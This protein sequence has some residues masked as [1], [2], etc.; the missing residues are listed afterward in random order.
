MGTYDKGVLADFELELLPDETEGSLS[1][2]KTERIQGSRK[3]S[4]R[5]FTDQAA[6]G[7]VEFVV[8]V[9]VFWF[10]GTRLQA[11]TIGLQRGAE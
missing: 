4:G 10:S 8:F 3:T 11:S 2:R 7:A 1:D 9:V 5:W 6:E